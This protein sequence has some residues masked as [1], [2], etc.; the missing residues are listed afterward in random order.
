MV[1]PVPGRVHHAALTR[2]DNTE[3]QMEI[4]TAGGSDVRLE[5]VLI[6]GTA[7]RLM[8]LLRARVLDDLRK[9]AGSS[10]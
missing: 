9:K 8:R 10:E 1:A 3:W 4:S 2:L 6:T 7:R 5:R